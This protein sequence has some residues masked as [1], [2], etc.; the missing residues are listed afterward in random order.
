MAYENK[1]YTALVIGIAIV[2]LLSTAHLF[3]FFSLSNGYSYDVLM[4]SYSPTEA[5]KR[6]IVIEL[7]SSYSKRGDEVWLTLLEQILRYDVQQ[8]AFTFLPEHATEQFYQLAADTL[9]LLSLITKM[10]NH[11]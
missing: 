6:L 8:V 10:K 5:S 9:V 4:R 3:S 1:K 7:D 2:I 11:H